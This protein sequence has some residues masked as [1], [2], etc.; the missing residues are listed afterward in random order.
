MHGNLKPVLMG[1]N[2]GV[3]PEINNQTTVNIIRPHRQ[4]VTKYSHKVP[5]ILSAPPPATIMCDSDYTTEL[6]NL[7]KP[8][9]LQQD[10]RC[11]ASIAVVP[12]TSSSD[13]ETICA[14]KQTVWTY[15]ATTDCGQVN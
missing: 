13:S 9:I 11:N 7:G 8:I 3:T 5:I 12:P 1:S 14:S 4:R 6:S 2:P 15:T 10:A